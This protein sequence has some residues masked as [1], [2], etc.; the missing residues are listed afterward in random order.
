M[1]CFLIFHYYLFLLIQFTVSLYYAENGSI[2]IVLVFDTLPLL[3]FDSPRT[4]KYKVR[5]WHCE[6]RDGRGRGRGRKGCQALCLGFRTSSMP[7]DECRLQK[8]SKGEDKC[9]T[10]RFW[11]GKVM[12]YFPD[13]FK[14][15]SNFRRMC[16][17]NSGNILEL[18]RWNGNINTLLTHDWS[19]IK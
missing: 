7:D 12:A 14:P 4:C 6:G 5:P 9:V 8:G 17:E 18:Q 2:I 10:H 3:W 19:N 16:L 15:L 11:N 13:W 1:L